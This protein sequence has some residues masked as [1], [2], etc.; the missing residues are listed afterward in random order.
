[1]CLATHLGPSCGSESM[2]WLTIFLYCS[3]DL[4]LLGPVVPVSNVFSTSAVLSIVSGIFHVVDITPRMIFSRLSHRN[5][6]LYRSNCQVVD[7][8]EENNCF[9]T[10]ISFKNGYSGSF[11]TCDIPLT[12]I[13]SSL[14][15]TTPTLSLHGIPLYGVC[16]NYS[17]IPAPKIP[18]IGHLI[19]AIPGTINVTFCNSSLRPRIAVEYEHSMLQTACA[20]CLHISL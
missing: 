2:T 12:I 19:S 4:L 16:V 3:D 20:V 5:R 13:P 6:K 7:N 10:L 8:Y 9:W 11:C 15:S 14:H 18:S 17:G 1:M